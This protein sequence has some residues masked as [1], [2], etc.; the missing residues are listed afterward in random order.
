MNQHMWS[1]M[2]IMERHVLSKKGKQSIL[3]VLSETYKKWVHQLA[4]FAQL[5]LSREWLSKDWSIFQPM[6]HLTNLNQIY[7]LIDKLREKLLVC[8][9]NG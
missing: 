9:S 1:K 2:Y 8:F 3:Q 6:Y 7:L 4:Q 5:W